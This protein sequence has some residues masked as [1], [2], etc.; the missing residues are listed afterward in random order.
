MSSSSGAAETLT[1]PAG[2]QANAPVA[3]TTMDAKLM[4]ATA[5]G[6]VQKLKDLVNKQEEDSKM[7]VVAMAKQQAAAAASAGNPH[8]HKGNMDPR[9]LALAS[10]GSSEELQTLLNGEHGQASG[11]SGNHG[12]L[13]IRRAWRG[14]LQKV[15]LHSMW[16][17]LVVRAMTSLPAGGVGA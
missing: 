5:S 1:S 4:V 10:S 8:P 6:D 13:P 3:T 7:M 14:S 15:T 2:Q 16:W 17:P 12:S 11:C 9:L